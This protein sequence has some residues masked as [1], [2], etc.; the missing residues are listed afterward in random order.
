M[1]NNFFIRKLT[2]LKRARVK[3]FLFINGIHPKQLLDRIIKRYYLMFYR[4]YI[5]N[6]NIID[7]EGETYLSYQGR[8]LNIENTLNNP[9]YINYK[10]YWYLWMPVNYE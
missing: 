9:Q 6:M 2:E 10:K 7:H 1:R 3:N 5:K 8:S 4:Y